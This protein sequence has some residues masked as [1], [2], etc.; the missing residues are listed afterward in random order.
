[1]KYILVLEAKRKNAKRHIVMRSDDINH[2]EDL[3]KNNI[4][5]SYKKSIYTA[6]WRLVKE[7]EEEEA[8]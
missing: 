7:I 2:L 1:M 8:K 5:N 4:N 6:N 3:A